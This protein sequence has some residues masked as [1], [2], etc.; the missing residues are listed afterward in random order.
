MFGLTDGVTHIIQLGDVLH[1][2]TSSA[3]CLI[4]F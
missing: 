3:K 1:F 4:L 2:D